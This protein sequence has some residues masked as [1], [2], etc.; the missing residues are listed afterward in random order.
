MAATTNPWNELLSDD[1]TKVI[2]LTVLG[3]SSLTIKLLNAFNSALVLLMLLKRKFCTE[4]SWFELTKLLA[5]LELM[6]SI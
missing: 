1:R 4:N 3:T 6:D 2:P 5:T